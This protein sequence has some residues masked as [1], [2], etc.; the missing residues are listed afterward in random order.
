MGLVGDGSRTIIV[1][2]R[3]GDPQT[4]ERASYG[5]HEVYSWWIIS[6]SMSSKPWPGRRLRSLISLGSGRS[7]VYSY[8]G[9]I[10]I[11]PVRNWEEVRRN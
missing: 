6:T 9:I 7:G 8:R 5:G 4:Y 11:V 2:V 1:L 3:S 10:K